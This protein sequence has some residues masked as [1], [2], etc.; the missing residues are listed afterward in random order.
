MSTHDAAA[1]RTRFREGAMATTNKQLVSVRLT[2]TD[3]VRIK[4]IA[5]RLGVR[6]SDVI[7]FALKTMLSKLAPLHNE[8]LSGKDLLPVFVELGAELTDYFEIDS[9]QLDGI[10]NN[11]IADASK[12]VQPEDLQ[13]LCM[14]GM[15]EHYMYAR[16]RELVKTPIESIG[17]AAALRLYLYEKYA[18]HAPRHNARND[19][20]EEE[21][22]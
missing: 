3:L 15:P 22:A 5:V 20:T 21:E 12:R 9:A 7:R 13:L 10:I 17:V 18:Q 19:A 2:T 16:L 4:R 8:S 6:D 11:G 14:A 1:K